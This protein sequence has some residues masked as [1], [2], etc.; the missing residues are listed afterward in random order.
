MFTGLL[1]THK[2][3]V[4]LFLVHYLIKTIL[5]FKNQGTLEKYTKKTRVP[6]MIISVLFLATGIGLGIDKGFG[7]LP[8]EFWIKIAMVFTSIP[9]A[10]IGFK[11]N[12]KALAA[13]S[14]LM[15][16]GAYG[17]AEMIKSKSAEAGNEQMEELRNESGSVSGQDVYTA[18]CVLC[19]GE[20]GDAN[21]SGA[22]DLTISKVS[23]AEAKDIVTNG[24]GYMTPFGSVLSE[25]EINAV[26]EY[27][28]TLKK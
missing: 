5:L 8:G 3:V 19:H 23:S 6:E 9:L 12:N 26:V 28:E 14:M 1:H 7:N 15:I 25:E 20:T 22:K 27:I 4:T 2:L 10:V 11:K 24:K 16:L 17:M 13:L 18:K 21:R